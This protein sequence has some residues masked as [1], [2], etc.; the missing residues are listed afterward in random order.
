MSFIPCLVDGAAPLGE[1]RYALGHP[2]LDRYLE[3]V[4]GRQRPCW[5][6]SRA[7]LRLR[8]VGVGEELAVGGVVDVALQRTDGVFLVCLGELAV[9]VDAAIGVQLANLADRGQVQRVVEPPV[10]SLR[11][12][13]DDPPA[14]GSLDRSGA[15]VSGEVIAAD[16]AGHVAGEADEVAGDDGPDADQLGEARL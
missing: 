10:A 9:E 16:E 13:V 1:P 6:P 8:A 2:L 14:G 5:V 7:R 4:A 15:V 11:D 3:F 12:A